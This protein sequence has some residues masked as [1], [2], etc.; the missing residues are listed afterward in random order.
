[1]ADTFSWR[2]PVVLAAGGIAGLGDQALT[3]TEYFAGD[4]RKI[5]TIVRLKMRSQGPAM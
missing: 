2:H 1:M 4:L 3:G 5:A